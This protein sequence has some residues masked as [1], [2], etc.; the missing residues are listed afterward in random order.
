MGMVAGN[1]ANAVGKRETM[2]NPVHH[3]ETSRLDNEG[4][5]EVNK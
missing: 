4:S 2:V 3:A 5:K 1:E